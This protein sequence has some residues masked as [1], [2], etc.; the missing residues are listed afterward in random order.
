MDNKH[1]LTSLEEQYL[2]NNMGSIKSIALDVTRYNVEKWLFD[3]NR[4]TYAIFYY[5]ETNV[6]DFD[7]FDLY[8]TAV[9]YENIILK[10]KGT[11]IAILELENGLVISIPKQYAEMDKDTN[12][13]QNLASIL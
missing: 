2:K 9:G 1:L 11:P 13:L 3:K 8:Q 5:T 6:L 12:I 7:V 4:I 10:N